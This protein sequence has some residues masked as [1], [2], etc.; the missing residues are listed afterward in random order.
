MY[1]VI[2]SLTDSLGPVHCGHWNMTSAVCKQK[3]TPNAAHY[4]NTLDYN[5]GNGTGATAATGQYAMVSQCMGA[6]AGFPNTGALADA[7]RDAG[8]NSLGCR[9]YHAQAALEAPLVHCQHA[10]PSGGDVCG[11]F[12]EAW[13]SLLAGAPCS[14]TLQISKLVTAVGMAKVNTLIPQ[15]AAGAG[16]YTTSLDNGGNTQAC[17]IYHLGVANTPAPTHCS[18][19]FISGGNNCGSYSANICDFIEGTCGFSGATATTWQF[20]SKAACLTALT[21]T[22]TNL[23]DAG[24]AGATS[25]ESYELVRAPF[26]T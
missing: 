19:G 10:G 17:R 7:N 15:K 3:V 11:S 2:A 14:D 18:H 23:I 16:A 24:I 9:E 26:T 12:L 1:H 20:A 25:G 8:V 4:C 13:T 6:A 22:T 5:C 21:N